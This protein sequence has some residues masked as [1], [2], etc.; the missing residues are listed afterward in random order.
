[1]DNRVEALLSKQERR[2]SVVLALSR[3]LLVRLLAMQVM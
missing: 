2:Q 3:S 1:M